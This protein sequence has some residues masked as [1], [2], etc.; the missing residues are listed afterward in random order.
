MAVNMLWAATDGPATVEDSVP[1]SLGT[2]FSV[3]S[4]AWLT[5]FRVWRAVTGD[6]GITCAA[7]AVGAGSPMPGSSV[8]VPD[9]GT[10]WQTVTLGSALP[11]T[12]GVRHIATAHHPLR[13]SGTGGYWLS[14]QPGGSGFTVGNLRAPSDA[15]VV[16]SPIGQG[17]Y[18]LGSSIAEPT[19][20]YQGACYW[21][22]P[23]TTDEDPA[24]ST[25]VGS[26]TFGGLASGVRAVVAAGSA[27]AVGSGSV[28][29]ARTAVAAAVGAASSGGSAD[30]LRAAIAAASGSGSS[31]GSA[32]G[33]R[34]AVALAVGTAESSAAA[35]GSRTAVST[36]TGGA[37][38]AGL[39]DGDGR[40]AVGSGIA[41]GLAT[42][43][44]LIRRPRRG[45]IHRP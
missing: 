30:G 10:G 9:G 39:V 1:I 45:V 2:E 33:G 22:T 28:A 36:A 29:G 15:E 43:H 5:G 38:G 21:I 17:R 40:T 13:Y 24:G 18:V 34:V 23:I 8:S 32:D 35:V 26:A 4:P 42:I 11:L 16:A 12:P 41:A 37:A 25:A 31:E 14:G 27:T 7:F 3:T 19:E 20:T 44:P 6:S